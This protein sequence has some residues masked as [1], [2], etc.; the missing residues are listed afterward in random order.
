M[1]PHPL[2][3]DSAFF[4]LTTFQSLLQF[5][6]LFLF[7]RTISLCLPSLY[8]LKGRRLSFWSVLPD[9]ASTVRKTATR[10]LVSIFWPT[11]WH[12]AHW[13][14]MTSDIKWAESRVAFE[15]GMGDANKTGSLCENDREYAWSRKFCS[16]WE[17][18][19]RLLKRMRDLRKTVQSTIYEKM[20]NICLFVCCAKASLHGS[21]QC[22]Q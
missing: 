12:S 3:F 13:E 20:L 4:P 10:P 7:L 11:H 2:F 19:T 1:R 22:I 8:S 6:S 21:I 17:D 9:S 16:S 5:H 14:W 18:N 15:S